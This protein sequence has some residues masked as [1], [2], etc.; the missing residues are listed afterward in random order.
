MHPHPL[1]DLRHTDGSEEL[2]PAQLDPAAF[3]ASVF[4][5]RRLPDRTHY[6]MVR[7]RRCGLVRSDPVLDAEAVASC[8]ETRPLTTATNSRG[9]VRPTARRLIGWQPS[10]SGDAVCWTSAV[11]AVSCSSW[12]RTVAGRRPGRRAEHRGDRRGTPGRPSAIV[13]DVMREGVSPPSRSM[14]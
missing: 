8:T 9:S 3:T 13:Q 12:R 6:R 7:C 4:S 2:Y 10:R 11:A 14:R 1:R 5:A